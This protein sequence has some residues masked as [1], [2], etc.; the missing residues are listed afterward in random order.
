MPIVDYWKLVLIEL[1]QTVSVGKYKAWLENLEFIATSERSTVINLS[2][3]SR[4]AKEYI[5]T[6]LEEQLLVAIKK[7]FTKIIFSLLNNW[8]Y[9]LFF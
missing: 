5:E 1:E 3:I 8:I 7:Y 9:E 6:K 4:F 2:T